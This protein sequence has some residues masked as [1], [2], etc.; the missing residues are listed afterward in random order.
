MSSAARRRWVVS[1]AM[2]R[3]SRAWWVP[4]GAHV[5]VRRRDPLGRRAH[6]VEPVVD[7]VQVGLLGGDLGIGTV[8]QRG[9]ERRGSQTVYEIRRAATAPRP[10]QPRRASDLAGGGDLDVVGVDEEE[11]LAELQAVGA[12][13]RPRGPRGSGSAPTRRRGAAPPPRSRPPWV[14]TST[15][16]V[17]G[18]AAAIVAQSAA[19]ARASEVLVRLE[20]GR[21]AVLGQVAGPLGARSRR[22]VM[23]RP[24]PRVDLLEPARRRSTLEP[25]AGADDLR[26]P[27]GPLQR[28]AP[29]SRSI[30]RP[31]AARAAQRPSTAS[32]A[33]RSP[34]SDSGGSARPCQR[35]SAFHV[36]LAVTGQEQPRLDSCGVTRSGR[37]RRR[38]RTRRCGRRARPAGPR[39]AAAG[40]PCAGSM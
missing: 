18:A 24:L 23:P 21:A 36:G 27:P 4:P 34:S 5:P 40:R 39:A 2:S 15:D 28:R 16:R 1:T 7:R 25:E 26:G 3:S 37:R 38:G 22:R 30:G 13:R 14:T 32:A 9:S 12:R 10:A 6:G 17:R 11:P 33:W 31:V 8:G 29:R 19:S 20:A 35:P